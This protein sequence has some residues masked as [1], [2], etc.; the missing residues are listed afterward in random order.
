[1]GLLDEQWADAIVRVQP[2]SHVTDETIAAV[3]KFLTFKKVAI[4]KFGSRAAGTILPTKTM[5]RH[6]KAKARD[7]VM[8]M[9]EQSA[10]A[11]ELKAL[12]DVELGKVRL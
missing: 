8:A 6:A 2:P 9:A 11:E 5:V 12:L 7:V 10:R 3:R 1:M 4:V